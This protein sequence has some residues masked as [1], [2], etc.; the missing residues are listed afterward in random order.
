MF[1]SLN[2]PVTSGSSSFTQPTPSL[3]AVSNDKPANN[4]FASSGLPIF[5][6]LNQ[7]S[8]NPTS[9]ESQGSNLFGKTQ[10]TAG[11]NTPSNLFGGFAA[12]KS[13]ATATTASQPSSTNLFQTVGSA[14][15]APVNQTAAPPVSAGFFPSTPQPSSST[16][17]ES[18]GPLFGRIAPQTAPPKTSSEVQNTT[19]TFGDALAR[20]QEMQKA[21]SAGASSTPSL[22]GTKPQIASPA[23]PAEPVSRNLFGGVGS[24]AAV[25]PRLPANA[26]AEMLQHFQRIDRST[27]HLLTALDASADWSDLLTRLAEDYKTSVS[28]I[29]GASRT[30]APAP[31]F[32]TKRKEQAD[33]PAEPSRPAKQ[34]NTTPAPQESSLQKEQSASSKK[35]ES[36]F[37]SSKTQQ[38][39]TPPP[40]PQRLFGQ[41]DGSSN[42]FTNTVPQNATSNT[43]KPNG[44]FSQPASTAN[45]FGS[46]N[47]QQSNNFGSPDEN[48]DGNRFNSPK[49]SSANIFGHVSNAHE[50]HEDEEGEDEEGTF[51][52]VLR[53]KPASTEKGLFDR[54]SGGPPP[55]NDS[56]EPEASEDGLAANGAEDEPHSLSETHSS[57][58]DHTWKTNDPIHFGDSANSQSTPKVNGSTNNIFG[59]PSAAQNPFNVSSTPAGLPAKAAENNLFGSKQPGSSFVFKPS[60][61]NLFVPKQPTTNQSSRATTPGTDINGVSASEAE[62]ESSAQETEITNGEVMADKTSLTT[63]ELS[64]E[65]ILYEVPKLKILQYLPV[66]GQEEEKE[67]RARGTGPFR[68][69]KN[70]STEEV[71]IL[72]RIAP[73]G[74][75]LINSRLLKGATFKKLANKGSLS[76]GAVGA[77]EGKEKTMTFQNYMARMASDETA[78]ELVRVLENNKESN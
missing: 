67:W 21:N 25:Q 29:G 78:K 69:L 72:H 52:D 14:Q 4:P 22:F 41:T 12:P 43:S 32:G 31:A 65:E 28:R 24:D 56:P 6:N 53:N 66:L 11:S 36:L 76:I 47:G 68:V 40:Q 51:E 7:P 75:V 49:A 17:A 44:M 10:E 16:T 1:G 23:K 60:E 3:F 15:N 30:G 18:P 35:F 62:G 8:S 2:A 55:K 42:V 64:K 59:M 9:T 63:E 39:S 57:A 5:N 50:I 37:N 45:I 73:S 26:T 19:N 61:N 54:I 48:N 58:G 27:L 46:T 70:K 34:A 13:G 74:K 71:R 20:S 77:T 38:G 33:P